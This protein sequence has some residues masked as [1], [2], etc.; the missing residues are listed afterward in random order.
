MTETSKKNSETFLE[1]ILVN[2]SLCYLFSLHN[3][4]YLQDV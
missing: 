2:P 3:V 1:Q 4:L